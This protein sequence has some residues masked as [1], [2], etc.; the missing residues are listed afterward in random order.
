VQEKK[1]TETIMTNSK[2]TDK[3]KVSLLYVEDDRLLR[4]VY[5][6]I[7]LS[8]VDEVYVAANGEEGLEAFQEH[9]PDII[10]TDVRMPVMNGLDMI[11]RIRKLDA[12]VRIVILSA[13]G[14]SRYY[15]GAIESGVKGYLLKPVDTDVLIN[16]IREQA[17]DI[18]LDK[19]VK[20]EEAKRWMAEKA[21]EK[22]EAILQS[23]AYGSAIFFREGFHDSSVKRVL[24]RLGESTGASRVYIFQNFTEGERS[25]TSQTFEWVMDGVKAEIDNPDLMRIYFDDPAFKRWVRVMEQGGSIHGIIRDFPEGDEKQILLAQDIQSILV[26][27]IY[28]DDYWWGFVGLDDCEQERYWSEGERKALET[29]ANNLGAAIY[30]RQVETEI[31]ELNA[32]LEKRVSE[33]TKA[34]EKEVAERRHTE[35]RLKESEEKYRLI[36]ENANNGILLVVE[37]RIVMVNPKV[38]EI[39]YYKPSSLI[40]SEFLDIVVEEDKE[41]FSG[42]LSNQFKA[43][44]VRSMD[45]RVKAASGQI[46]WLDVKTNQ[47]NWDEYP[48]CLLF[49]SDISARKKAEDELNRL[50]SEL[51]DRVAKEVEKVKQQQQLLVQKSKLEFI[52]ELSAGLS[53]E[54]NQPLGGISM[55]LDNIL[56]RLD[57]EGLDKQYIRDKFGLLFKDIERINQIIQ[58]V[59]IFS[60]D[61]QI[62]F[63]EKV[64]V[65]E[66]IQNALSMVQMQ[67]KDHQIDLQL[68]LPI[69]PVFVMGNPYRLEQVI[70]NLLSNARFAVEEKEKKLQ[71]KAYL[72]T[73]EI[74]CEST[75]KNCTIEVRDNGTGIPHQYVNNIF[76]PF[77]TTKNEE[78]GTGLGLSISYGIVREFGGRIRVDSKE[79]EYSNFIVT[80][81]LKTDKHE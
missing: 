33:R 30:R 76:N 69:K 7:L 41:A 17:N 55:G 50:N 37:N 43:E 59:R 40:G 56:M 16:M 26:V 47:I 21:M 15:L 22:S 49:I 65:S 35:I 13:F 62:T 70:L 38:I 18:L 24:T 68:H 52:G 36:Y 77:F 73:I 20:E 25:Y 32:N 81:P 51:E 12:D 5:R 3:L 9:H 29:M 74:R 63:S 48:A 23:V 80:L 78:K 39:L 61:Q 1:N 54:I 60:R 11:R 57:D 44:S 27:P 58:H 64:N 46:K 79:D 34:L 31:L 75:G 72:K 6:N 66:V 53:H 4:N 19:K 28:V 45:V 71:D 42:F 2:T 14:E 10:L 8:I 67:M